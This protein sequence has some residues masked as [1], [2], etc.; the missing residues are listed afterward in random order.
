MK[1]R[2]DSKKSKTDTTANKNLGSK[3]AKDR[4]GT[5]AGGFKNSGTK[6]TQKR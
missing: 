1:N 2:D 5:N 6:G 3:T 4:S